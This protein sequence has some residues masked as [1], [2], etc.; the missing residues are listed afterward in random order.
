MGDG[1]EYTFYKGALYS[2]MKN[3]EEYLLDGVA[4]NYYRALTD[5]DID[6]I[7]FVPPAIPFH[8]LHFWKLATKKA[9]TGKVLVYP[10]HDRVTIETS[11]RTAGITNGKIT[12]VIYP[13]GV[14]DI[15]HEG[16]ATNDM[17][18]F[19]MR[20]VLPKELSSVKWYGRGPQET[21]CDRKTGAKIGVYEKSVKDLEHHGPVPVQRRTAVVSPVQPDVDGIVGKGK[22]R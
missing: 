22:R 4:Q 17:L 11:L 12:Y 20:F 14:I 9:S 19:G 5:N 8:P 15:K 7:N 1:F 16:K 6:Y 3:G 10:Y 2:L 13:D 21:Y 18:R